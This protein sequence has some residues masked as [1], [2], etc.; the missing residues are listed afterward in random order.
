M[1]SDNQAAL[2]RLKTPSDRPGQACQI[3]AIKAAKKVRSKG[4]NIRLN[5]VPGHRDILRN[6]LADALA[7]EATFEDP[8]IKETS[9]AFLGTLLRKT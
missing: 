9:F 4:A 8:S 7:K 1:F 5:W 6:E 2:Y 3:R